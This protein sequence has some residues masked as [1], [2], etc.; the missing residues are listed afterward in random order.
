MLPGELKEAV[1][2]WLERQ[3]GAA[4]RGQSTK[5]REAYKL[6]RNSA[7]VDLA[8]YLTTRMPAT[9]A[10]VTKV[11][12]EVA[13]HVSPRSILD[14]GAGP[15]T[16]SWAALTVW[17]DIGDIT[18]VEADARFVDLAKLLATESLMPALSSA[19]IVNARMV[20][21]STKAE[22][23]VA[24]YVFAELAEQE[25][26]NSALKLLAQTEHT[27]VIVEPG[28]P[29]GFARI[30]AARVALLQAGVHMVGPC[31]HVNPCPMAGGNWC[32]F[33][34]RLARSREHMHAKQA[35]VPFEDEPFSWIAVSRFPTQLAQA[36]IMGPVEY[37]KH[38]MC[39][40]I[41]DG[42]GISKRT[43]ARRD[44]AAYKS[45]RKLAWGDAI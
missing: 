11:L 18:M 30:R 4:L 8:A 15:G 40:K 20:D 2:L 26:A 35:N 44:K 39:F 27:L 29:L 41:C 37:L 34:Q 23:V 25:A 22:L 21:V 9:F 17:P 1:G 12:N 33:T 10:A 3:S 28:T 45:N 19:D 16:A 42:Q 5:L 24:A 13:R 38:E 14:V 36:R 7:H 31:T 43:V 32:H 6:G